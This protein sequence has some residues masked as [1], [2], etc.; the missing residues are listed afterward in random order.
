[1]YVIAI[2]WLYVV[3]LMALAETS[4]VAG[5]ASL[6]FYG[7]LPVALLLW[8]TGTPLRRRR[9]A[10]QETLPAASDANPKEE[11]PRADAAASDLPSRD[12][13]TRIDAPPSSPKG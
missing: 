12:V 4:A 11:S 13:E 1:M 6:V 2:G 10:A 9:R 5:V 8:L 7:I 3:V